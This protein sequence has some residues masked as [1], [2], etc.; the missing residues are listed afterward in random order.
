MKGIEICGQNKGIAQSHKS[1]IEADRTTILTKYSGIATLSTKSK[2]YLV[3]IP[4]TAHEYSMYRNWHSISCTT[5]SV[6]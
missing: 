2:T 3:T 5:G 4:L 6:Y 1:G